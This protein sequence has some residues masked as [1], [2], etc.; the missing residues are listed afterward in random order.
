MRVMARSYD[1]GVLDFVRIL[2]VGA[3][4]VAFYTAYYIRDAT[5]FPVIMNYLLEDYLQIPMTTDYQVENLER[6]LWLIIP[7]WLFL[8]S[9]LNTYDFGRT[10]TFFNIVQDIFKVHVAGA[11]ITG[12]F[13]FLT[14]AYEYKRSFFFLYFIL[15]FMLMLAIRFG[16]HAVLRFLRTGDRF[17]NRAVIVGNDKKALKALTELKGHPYWGFNIVGI[18]SEGPFQEKNILGLPVLGSKED[19]ERILR[20]NPIDDVFVAMEEG[21]YFELKNILRICENIGVTVHLIPDKYDL[22][23]ASSTIGSL[24]HMDFVTFST[25]PTNIAQRIAKRG[26]DIVIS[27]L[28]L[29]ILTVFYAVVGILIKLDSPGPVIYKSRRL[30]RNRRLFTFYKFRTMV[31]GA[32]EKFELVSKQNKMEGPISKIEDD[33]RVTKL[34]RYLR[35]YSIDELPQVIN[36]LWGDMSLVGPRPPTREEVEHYSLAQLRKLSM[37]QGI[38]G[39]W[40]VEGRDRIVKFEDRLKLDLKYIDNWSFW[41]DVRILFKTFFVVFKGAM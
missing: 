7:L 26:M 37:Q 21:K 16:V 15:S 35:K 41:L 13:I 12:T 5:Y 22:E 24:G 33:P 23:I 17:H 25:I 1:R 29:P 11:F 4:F 40:Q 19:I 34:G 27:L 9:Y 8:L 3:I 28:L 18:V 10:A 20:K 30:T 6:I 36:V 14:N 2:D 32:E 38:T 31:A 39:L